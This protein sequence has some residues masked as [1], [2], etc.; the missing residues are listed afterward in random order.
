MV[1]IASTASGKS[2]LLSGKPGHKTAAANLA[3]RLQG[4]ENAKQ[5]SP[6]RRER[7]SSEKVADDHAPSTQ[8]LTGKQLDPGNFGDMILNSRPVFA[9][10]TVSNGIKFRV[11]EIPEI[12]GISEIPPEEGPAAEAGTPGCFL[13]PFQEGRCRE[14]P[15][16]F[17]QASQVVKAVGGHQARSHQLPESLLNLY[18]KPAGHLHQLGH[19]TGS[20]LLEGFQHLLR[21]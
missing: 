14:A 3:A 1:R 6:R 11:P 15:F 20:A 19:E 9:T 5:F 21:L 2:K 4:S 17:D 8:Q 13:P 12:P 10:R 18:G 7:F 16:R